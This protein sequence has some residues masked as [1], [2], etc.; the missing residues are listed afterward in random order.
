[1]IEK[2]D[3]SEDLAR[4][5][6]A[7]AREAV[8]SYIREEKTIKVSSGDEIF[9]R[10]LGVFVTIRKGSSLRGCIGYTEPPWPLGITLIRAAIAS[11]TEDPRFPSITPQELDDLFYEVTIL[12]E[13]REIHINDEQ[14]LGKIRLGINGLMIDSYGRTGLLLPQVA[15]EEGFDAVDFLDVT[16]EKAG[17]MPGCWKS[18]GTKIYIFEGIVYKENQD[19]KKKKL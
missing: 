15:L 16:C 3:H 11:G 12:T 17:L 8:E 2:H 14:D 5:L 4:L 9:R 6:P 1:M 7:L 10:K 18:K 19:Q 13:P